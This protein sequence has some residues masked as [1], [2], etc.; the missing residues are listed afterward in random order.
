MNL[1]EYRDLSFS[2]SSSELLLEN[3]K[4][5]EPNGTENS[6]PDINTILLLSTLLLA[7]NEEMKLKKNQAHCKRAKIK[8][9]LYFNMLV[10]KN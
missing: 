6:K 3:Y 8:V 9:N 7:S 1:K 10:I 5:V 4:K 2:I